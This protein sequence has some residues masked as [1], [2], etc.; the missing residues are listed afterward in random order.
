M[1]NFRVS[2]NRLLLIIK[3]AGLLV[4]LL[5]IGLW[6]CSEDNTVDPNVGGNTG[7][8]EG[9]GVSGLLFENNLVMYFRENDGSRSELFPQMYFTRA[10]AQ[11]FPVWG[12]F[13]NNLM[14]SGGV[15][16][17]GIPA[18]TN[19]GF[20]PPGSTELRYLQDSD[21]VLGVVM[22]SVVKAYPEKILW[23][24]EIVNDMIGSEKIIVTLCPLTGTGLVFRAPENGNI[25]DE[26]ELLPVVETTWMKWK[27]LYPQT[28][29]ISMNTGFGFVYNTYP[30][31]SYRSENTLPLFP[32]R[33]GDIDT[34][35]P[36][37]H[38][39]LGL[40]Q[41]DV[42]KAYPFSKLENDPVVN[43]VI[44]GRE[45]L[46]VSDMTQKL[47]IPYDRTVNQ[48]LLNFTFVSDT[49]FKM[50]DNETGSSWNIKGEAMSGPMV[51]NTLEQ[52]PAYNAFW[53]AWAIFWPQTLV[54][55]E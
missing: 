11:N 25:I 29:A 13:P 34:R 54:F 17:D 40:L 4:F 52:I 20:V 55:G 10:D 19:P 44:N 26:L 53:F 48:Q 43:D 45:V 24:H 37:K 50:I 14:V 47:A 31:G 32:L 15:P 1:K 27:E 42:R 9:F 21:L 36:P 35:F 16:R 2:V 8:F 18:L 30:Y 7:P 49:V 38:T 3:T 23:S 12:Q 22:D 33:T 5:G 28:T 6:G 51:G 41:G 46:I 39:V